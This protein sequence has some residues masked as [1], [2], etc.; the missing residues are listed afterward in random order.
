MELGATMSGSWRKKLNTG[1]STEYEL[2]GIDNGIKS[3][4]WGLYFIQAKGYKVANN[5]LMQDKKL[6]NMLAKNGHFSSSKR[7]KYIKNRY[8]MIKGNF[9]KGEI[10]I[11]YCPTGDMLDTIWPRMAIFLAPKGPSISKTG[12]L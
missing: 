8:F 11:Q 12:T 3:I 9:G 4:M 5:I 6:T 10:V 2:V 1:R 7:T